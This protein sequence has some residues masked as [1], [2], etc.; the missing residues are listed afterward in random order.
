M[1]DKHCSPR[2]TQELK[3]LESTIEK[4]FFMIHCEC[5]AHVWPLGV[6]QSLPT[7]SYMSSGT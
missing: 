4:S 3:T 7:V 1:K 2:I 5:K 6:I